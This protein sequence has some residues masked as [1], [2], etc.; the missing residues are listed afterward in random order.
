MKH[1]IIDGNNVIHKI[2]SFV[3]LVQKDK[4]APREKLVFMIERYFQGRKAKITLHY[5][6]FENLPIKTS[7]IKIIYSN[8]KT[9]DEKIR[10]QIED[11][12]NGKNIIVI[13]SDD[14]IKAFAR[15]CRCEVIP[16]EDFIKQIQ[17][18]GQVDE[19]T[20][21]INSINNSEYFRKLFNDD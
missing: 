6:G 1:Y 17:S 2:S 18:M 14:G 8:K 16:S 15:K 21:R 13:T 19:E 5:D 20:A 9:A 7:F 10:Q 3:R 4:Q 11:A 12:D